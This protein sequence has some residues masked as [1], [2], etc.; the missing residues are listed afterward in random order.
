VESDPV[1]APSEEQ[2]A[3]GS[4]DT[5]PATVAA[6]GSDAAP[7]SGLY[8]EH[9]YRTYA[10]LEYDRNEPHW[11]WFF[12]MLADNI[13]R[14]INPRT[15]LDAGCAK[16]FLVEAL[17]DRG[18]EAYGI[19]ASEY[20]ISCVR[21]DV[22]PYCKVGSITE[23]LDRDYDLITCLEVLEHLPLADS[24][25]AMANLCRHT[26]DIVFSS[27]PTNAGEATHINIHP[28]E[29]W[30]ERFAQQSFYRDVDY[31]ASYVAWWTVR[32]RRSRDPL[33]R[34][35]GELER[36][37]ART[38][39]ESRERA[40]IVLRQEREL[41]EGTAEIARL[42]EA[43]EKA[44]TEV[45]RELGPS[46]AQ[47]DE[48]ITAL[49]Q[50]E[51]VIVDTERRRA[52]A[53]RRRAEAERI[54]EDMRRIEQSPSYRAARKVSRGIRRVLPAESRRG[55]LA[56]TGVHGVVLLGDQGPAALARRL[57]E[58]MRN[59][60]LAT[61]NLM[62][63][64]EMQ[65]AALFDEAGQQE[66]EKWLVGSA[67]TGR[68]LARMRELS[69]EFASRPLVSIVMPAYNSDESWL[70]EAIQSVREQAYENW[71]L[72]IA[73]DCSPDPRV[74][75]VLQE[76]A[77]FD[78]RVKLVFREQNG[79]IAQ[80]SNSALEIATGDWVGLL[81]HDDLL[82][83]HAL[84]RMVE[85][86]NAEPDADLIYSDEDKLFPDG[87]RGMPF[88]K[89]D[90]SPD[91]LTSINYVCHFTVIR[92]SVL[93]AVGGFRA[94]YDG[95]Q[96]HELFLRITDGGARV[97][98]VPDI[99][100][101]WRMLPGSSALNPDAKPRAAVARRQAIEES[102][103]RR[104]LSATVER[105]AQPGWY[106]VRYPLRGTPR[107][108][109]IIPTR[110]RVD[111]LRACVESIQQVS[112]YRDVRVVIIDNDSRDPQ[113]L[114]Y[115][116]N[117]DF[118]VIPH[119]GNFNYAAIMNHG[120]R[121]LDPLPDEHLLFLNNDMEVR[122]P[123]WVEA[124][125]EQSQRP[126]VGAVGCRLLYPDG[127]PQHEGVVIGMGGTA[128]NIDFSGYF[129]L[130]LLVRDVGAVTG[131]AMMM[132][133]STFEEIDGF[134]ET[135]RVAFN[136]VDLCMRLRQHGYRVVY[137]P[138]AEL[139]HFESASRGRMHPFED[140]ARFAERWGSG[141][142]LTDPFGNRNVLWYRPLRLRAWPVLPP[143]A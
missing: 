68:D 10:G 75:E 23:E 7:L 105:A 52:E 16:G 129:G 131:A 1:S 143:S 6:N 54:A 61:P 127:T 73:E 76:E 101:T 119:P 56:T 49:S 4:Q 72:C 29:W 83:P 28:P 38:L 71:E 95:S 125:L 98:H 78:S 50:S 9:Y 43:L 92:K 37:Y 40:E 142:D 85:Q 81:D 64:S 17:R 3:V 18:V 141:D 135:L 133:R 121:A 42:R 139:L 79:G 118:T 97:S 96:D 41:E 134:D 90:W 86:I 94:G 136:D 33:P 51:S 126:E 58:R 26:G 132:R 20:A 35:I 122:T 91:L 87:R 24:I 47:V 138:L 80:A 5:E 111:L 137:T 69:R 30:A 32:L 65:A 113:T 11:A 123:D 106:H 62:T 45:E 108:S 27:S 53:E 107:V 74:R 14:D 93:D 84:Y 115:L 57:R 109:I 15:V 22:K 99:L 103:Q 67:P 120:V 39:F 124:M 46:R 21:D 110:D 25:N 44:T 36:L 104:G 70:R 88:F 55:R 59:R 60:S 66:Y 48:L 8:D 117:P 13:V 77:S 100:Y 63:P 116:R 31:D 140:E 34:I 112:T 130:G 12:G 114:E 2:E 128:N 102:V 19:D 89:P 82:Q